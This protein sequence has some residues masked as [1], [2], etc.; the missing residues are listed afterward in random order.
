[1]VFLQGSEYKKIDKEIRKDLNYSIADGMGASIMSALTSGV[2]LAG[3]AILLGATPLQI[4][5]LSSL[6]LFANAFQIIGSYFIETGTSRKFV[7][8]TGSLIA[9]LLWVL[10]MLVPVFMFQSKIAVWLIIAVFTIS[11]ICSSASG[12]AWLYW[13]S[14][15]VPKNL[16]GRFFS[17]RN[18]Y[19]GVGGIA[20]SLLA[21]LFLDIWKINHPP[22]SGFLILYSVAIVFG[23]LS[24][25]FL[26]LIKD[27]RIKGKPV[28]HNVFT[29]L[30]QR[31]YRDSNFRK[32]V[33]FGIFWGFAVGLAGPFFI[34]Y[35]LKVINLD[36]LVVVALETLFG[37]S[38]LLSLKIWGKVVD[39]YGAKPVLV[40]CTFLIAL[41]PLFYIFLRKSDYLLLFPIN[42]VVG[43]AWAGTDFTTTQL[44]LRISPRENKSVY[45][46]SFAAATGLAF[47][48]AAIIGGILAT[49]VI[50][51]SYTISF[52][53]L[54]GLHILFLVAAILR[55]WSSTL[56]KS[57]KEPMSGNVRSVI[58]H[59][60]QD[61]VMNIFIN[62]YQFSQL[63]FSLI[64]L[65]LIYSAK[66]FQEGQK[67]LNQLRRR[68]RRALRDLDSIMKSPWIYKN[69]ELNRLAS[70]LKVVGKEIGRLEEDIEYASDETVLGTIRSETEKSIKHV[71]KIEKMLNA[72]RKRK[73]KVG[74]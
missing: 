38:G 49:Y 61:R 35:M 43:V 52:V 14:D 60:K 72:I 69:K 25:L 3:F 13:T 22:L 30:V 19:L 67:V 32:L 15:I 59:L 34:V 73:R 31:P 1:M 21:G 12:V 64:T 20:A 7:T 45:M 9:R 28:S 46:S 4:G 5:I 54:Y 68:T 74:K 65:P 71:A 58:S 17:R 29:D 66:A 16:L 40:I 50:N 44:L 11:S 57:V 36:Y 18:I 26:G 2:F 55:L 39:K 48:A 51:L 27:V 33:R 62:F 24:V 47:A 56:I 70:S 63:S 6:P 8:V 42:A 41:Y 37:V 53:T 10:I 23:L